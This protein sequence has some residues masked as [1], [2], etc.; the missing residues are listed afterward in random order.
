MEQNRKPRKVKPSKEK[1]IEEPIIEESIDISQ[2]PETKT[3]NGLG[4]VVKT[5]TNA[6]GLTTCDNCEER[7]KKMN[8]L[9]PFTKTAKRELTED[10]VEFIKGLTKTITSEE[11]YRIGD[12]YTSTYNVRFNHCNCPS[13]Y[14][15]AIDKLK[16][17]IEYQSI[18]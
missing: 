18:K 6:I 5:I 15:Q 12:I 13:V 2:E 14:K 4:D 10:E 1:A 7:R 16:I 17:Q 9:M 8:K 11:R 3:I